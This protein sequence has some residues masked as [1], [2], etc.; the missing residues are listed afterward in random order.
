[1]KLEKNNNNNKK[2]RIILRKS[3]NYKVVEKRF[4]F[5]IVMRQMKIEK[6][7]KNGNRTMR[8]IE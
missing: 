6:E 8:N 1:M 2:W 5:K 7:Q 3:K 4:G